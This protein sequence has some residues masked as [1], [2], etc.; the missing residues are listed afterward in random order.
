MKFKSE[1][2]KELLLRELSNDLDFD[3]EITLED[4]DKSEVKSAISVKRGKLLTKLKNF[5]KS[6]VQKQNWR[7][8][9][10]KYLKGIRQFHK[11]VAGKRFHRALARFVTSRGVLKKPKTKTTY[12][13]SS[14]LRE[15]LQFERYEYQAVPLGRYE[16]SE[17]LALLAATKNHLILETKYFLPISEEVDHLVMLEVV[18]PELTELC[19]RLEMSIINYDTFVLTEEEVDL[20]D[21]FLGSNYYDDN[22][23]HEIEI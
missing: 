5:R 19:T 3:E 12:G 13:T 23:E 21:S 20:I 18:L 11:S 22:E 15:S 7:K 6:Q 9:K 2:D 14:R 10:H 1:V 4:L 8:G 17:L 16:Q